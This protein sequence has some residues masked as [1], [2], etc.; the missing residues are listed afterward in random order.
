MKTIRRAIA[1]ERLPAHRPTGVRRVLIEA[2]ALDQWRHGKPS[3]RAERSSRPRASPLHP[4]VADERAP[5][6]AGSLGRL[7]E[8]ELRRG[9]P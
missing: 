3:R 2:A 9:A 6:T 8:I 5:T 1:A 7:H 4:A